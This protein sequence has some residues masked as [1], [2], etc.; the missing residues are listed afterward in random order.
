MS[1][2][3]IQFIKDASSKLAL[4]QSDESFARNLIDAYNVSARRA[5]IPEIKSLDELKAGSNDTDK[6]FNY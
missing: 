4:K 6:Y 5:W 3:D 2:K 1:D